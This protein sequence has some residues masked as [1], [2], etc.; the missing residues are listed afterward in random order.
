MV[1]VETTLTA[2]AVV[3]GERSERGVVMSGAQLEE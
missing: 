3:G 2:A 1:V